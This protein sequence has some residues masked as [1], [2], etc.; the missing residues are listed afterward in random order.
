MRKSRKILLIIIAVV[1]ALGAIGGTYFYDRRY[2]RKTAQNLPV[3]YNA[4]AL[5]NANAQTPAATAATNPSNLGFATK[6]MLDGTEVAPDGF[7]REN[8][9]SFSNGNSYTDAE[10]I[11][12]FRGNNYRDSASY[13]S[14]AIAQAK[15]SAEYWEYKTGSL[16]KGDLTQA[17][18]SDEWSGSGWT[19][20]P[21]IVKWDEQTKQVMNL[22]PEK[23]EKANLVE[24]I[25][26]TM[27]GNVHFLDLEDG[28]ATRD[29]LNIGLPFKGAGALDPR[30]YPILYVG[31]GDSLPS[32]VNNGQARVFIYSLVDFTLLHEFGASDPFSPREFHAYDSSAF[33]DA[34]TDT[35][36]YPGENSILY[37]MKLN[38]EY[39]P[40]TGALSIDPTEEVKWTYSTDRTSEESFWWGMEDSASI[41]GGYMYVCDN[42]GN[43]MCI[44]LNTMQ[45]VWAQDIM[46]DANASP[47]FEEDANGNKYVY[48][49]PSLHWQQD[50][51]TNTGRISIYKLNAMTGEIIWEKPY[52]VH[53]V[54]GISGGVQA[55]A[56]LGQGKISDLLIVPVARTPQKRNGQLVALDRETGEERWVFDMANYAW[57]S[58]V[59]IYAQD[60]TAYIVQCDSA[61]NIHLLNGMDGTLLDTLSIGSN[62]EASPAVYENTIVVGTRGKQIVGVTI[63]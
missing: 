25:Y 55:T 15:L 34:E 60:G 38:T 57:T 23:K 48:A 43:M 26:A 19:G 21:L 1:V 10:G 22:Y 61:G 17:K 47:I 46:D 30:G 36:L 31:A 4:A 62:I 8:E 52:E 58:P 13:G 45:L 27:D 40:A 54:D 37:T 49:A 51:K 2:G 7:S 50:P 11:I 5:E 12:T 39:D 56:V 32:S 59:A 35:L 14:P 6:L 33:V 18:G 16:P 44:D 41:W 9:I 53:T 28:T 29:K 42:A 3:Q 24:V 20:Q 63:E